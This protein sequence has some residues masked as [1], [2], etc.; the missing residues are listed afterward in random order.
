METKMKNVLLAACASLFLF[1][2]CQ[3]EQQGAG[4]VGEYNTL[5]VKKEN[6]EL[7]SSYSATIRGRQDIEIYPQVGGTL[8]KLCVVEGQRVRKGQTLFIID[9]VPYQAALKTAVAN[10]TA[11]KA[12]LATARLT[13]QSKKNLFDQH[14]VS[15]FDLQQAQNS[16]LSA[17]AALAQA[18]AQRINAENSLSYTVV[19]SPAD[20]VVGTLPYRQGALVGSNIPQPLTVVSDNSQM[21][22]YFSMTEN[23]LLS[24]AREYGTLDKAIEQMPEVKLQLSDG[25]EYEQT[26]RIETIS[27]VVDPSTGAVSLRAAFPNPSQ[28]LH[29]GSS[30][31]IILPVHYH[32]IVI[33][34]GATFSLQDKIL[35]YKI[36]EGK[37]T[38]THITVAPTN[39][40]TE[41]IVLDGLQPG[42][43]IIAEGAGLIREGTPVKSAAKK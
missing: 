4:Q 10:V 22:V 13:Y 26:G 2:S 29:S 6:R 35:V 3:N 19:S 25:S 33:P 18:E 12:A 36:V 27:G 1:I 9:Q 42:D 21:Y 16:M 37:A 11:A 34:Q 8:Q 41:Y 43:E 39:N 5:V 32:N 7:S 31:N 20:G 38:G 30:G 28:L 40:G 15:D 23:E 14:I 17:E 24:L